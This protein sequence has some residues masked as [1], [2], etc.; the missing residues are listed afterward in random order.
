VQRKA[1]CTT[2]GIFFSI[3]I[4]IM[5]SM[6]DLT[7]GSESWAEGHDSDADMLDFDESLGSAGRKSAKSQKA[8]NTHQIMPLAIRLRAP[9]RSLL[10]QAD[11]ALENIY[12]D[13]D[14]IS[15]QVGKLWRT[16]NYVNPFIGF[17][18]WSQQTKDRYRDAD[19]SLGREYLVVVMHS[20]SFKTALKSLTEEDWDRLHERVY[21]NRGSLR[22]FA[23]MR[24]IPYS[25]NYEKSNLPGLIG[26][27]GAH[28]F[29]A[30]HFPSGVEDI[31]QVFLGG[32]DNEKKN[33]EVA[34]IEGSV[35]QTV[36]EPV[37]DPSIFKKRE[38]HPDWPAD[39]PYP[40]NPTYPGLSVKKP[41]PYWS[42]CMKC[43][44]SVVSEKVARITPDDQRC[45]CK[46]EDVLVA[47]RPLL[48]VYQFSPITGDKASIN[49]GVRALSRVKKGAVLGEYTGQLIPK[50]DID[51]SSKDDPYAF[52]FCGP[53]ERDKS[54]RQ[55]ESTVVISYVTSRLVGN[56]T[57]FINQKG[58]VRMGN[59]CEFYQRTTAGQSRI[60]LI[61]KTDISF[62]EELTAFY[63]E[64]YF[65]PVKKVGKRRKL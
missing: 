62:G 12:R 45:L 20:P 14:N 46:L 24:R 47:P 59:N 9:R 32:K 63:G 8:G 35:V 30:E 40:Y 23:I 38:K 51:D 39:W 64:K 27:F 17:D 2:D 34:R 11:Q 22:M 49:R 25:R 52:D 57:R 10:E 18:R 15:L 44:K 5:E 29:V 43:S 48:E 3:K 16:F 56:W 33:I 60:L 7:K 53:S 50:Q 21:N 31:D 4:V 37:Y 58:T 13:I 26:S 41:P 65:E 1:L 28:M 61:A 55:I 19:K 6:I 54:G 36:L 42:D